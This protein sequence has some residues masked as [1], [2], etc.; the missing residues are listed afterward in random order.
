MKLFLPAATALVL[1]AASL[2]VYAV[3]PELVGE[4]VPV[5]SPVNRTI[6]VDSK[7]KWVNVTQGETV[8][9]VVNGYE[10][11]FAFDGQTGVFDLQQIVPAGT[12]D[13]SV[14]VYVSGRNE[15]D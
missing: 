9:F 4:S 14:K 2:G 11:V 10:T 8:K 12:L 3:S 15:F 1:S 13:R 7:A 5:A 6:V